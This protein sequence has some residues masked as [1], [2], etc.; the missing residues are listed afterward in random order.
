M[1]IFNT[2]QHGYKNAEKGKS[3]FDGYCNEIGSQN[4]IFGKNKVKHNTPPYNLHFKYMWIVNKF[5]DQCIMHKI[6][7]Y[8]SLS[9]WFII[10]GKQLQNVLGPLLPL[11]PL[12]QDQD[13]APG[14]ENQDQDHAPGRQNQDQDQMMVTV[15]KLIVEAATVDHAVDLLPHQD[16]DQDH[17]HLQ[18]G[19]THDQ[20]L[21]HMSAGEIHVPDRGHHQIV[22]VGQDHQVNI[23]RVLDQEA[24]I[25]GQMLLVVHNI[26]STLSLKSKWVFTNI[27]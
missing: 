3:W 1:Y 7:T 22:I 25:V 23:E 13:H 15:A 2:L 11:P 5:H 14:R 17:H 20:G 10:A 19:G 21:R 12:R 6:C 8:I 16:H 9:I 26:T 27:C 18:G 24:Q 4:D